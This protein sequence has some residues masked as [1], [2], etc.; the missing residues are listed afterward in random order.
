M[1]TLNMNRKIRYVYLGILILLT[2]T[3]F[4]L[5]GVNRQTSIN[6]SD[7]VTD[8]IVDALEIIDVTVNDN[9]INTLSSIVRKFF[10]HFLLFLIEGIFAYL[11]LI[12]FKKLEK[13]LFHLLIPFAFIILVGFLSEGVQYFADGRGASFIDVLIN[14]SGGMVGILFIYLVTRKKY[15][16]KELAL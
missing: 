11:S 4:I 9:Q 10:G 16:S 7:F 13:N 14:T 6:Q 8:T 3:I 1:Y 15:L 2:T 5:S 12:N